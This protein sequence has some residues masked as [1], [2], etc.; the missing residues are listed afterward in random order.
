VDGGSNPYLINDSLVIQPQGYLIFTRKE[1]AIILNNDKDSVRLLDPA[2]KVVNSVVYSSSKS[3]QSYANLSDG[4]AWTTKMTPGESNI[5]PA[6][7]IIGGERS[8]DPAHVFAKYSLGTT[9]LVKT[10]YAK[11]PSG[12]EAQTLFQISG[13]QVVAAN[14]GKLVTLSGEVIDKSGRKFFLEDNVGE[15]TAYL[16]TSIDFDMGSLAAGD[17]IKVTGIVKKYTDG[18]R[19]ALRTVD[20]IVVVEK[21]PIVD[22]AK[23]FDVREPSSKKGIFYAIAGGMLVLSGAIVVLKKR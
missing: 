22:I 9:S 10:A 17:K 5:S 21:A 12:G 2:G 3:G 7:E 16:K 18:F 13:D 4:W 19:V 11:A 8:D 1:T 6:S 20:D 23:A 14:E 15:A